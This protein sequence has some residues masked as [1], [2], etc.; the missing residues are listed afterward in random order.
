MLDTDDVVCVLQVACIITSM[1]RIRK[2]AAY[3]Q[4]QSTVPRVKDNNYRCVKRFAVL[5]LS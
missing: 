5:A 3:P 2:L 1:L 4:V